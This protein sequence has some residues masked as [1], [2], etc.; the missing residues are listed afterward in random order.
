MLFIPR[1]GVRVFAA[2]TYGV[3]C[4][5]VGLRCMSY[6]DPDYWTTI[7]TG[8]SEGQDDVANAAQPLGLHWGV[9]VE[10][11]VRLLMPALL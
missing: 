6:G 2:I 5:W 10:A 11:K 1:R 9:G 8:L 4:I 3:K 7:Q